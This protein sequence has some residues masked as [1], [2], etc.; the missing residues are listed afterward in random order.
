MAQLSL[1][2]SDQEVKVALY[3][4]IAIITHFS[5]FYVNLISH[6]KNA[7]TKAPVKLIYFFLKPFTTSKNLLLP[8]CEKNNKPICFRKSFVKYNIMQLSMYNLFFTSDNSMLG[9]KNGANRLH[10]EFS[11]NPAAHWHARD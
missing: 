6:K 7:K 1:I 10:F 9:H 8:G 2:F 3:I 4:V 11:C 5:R